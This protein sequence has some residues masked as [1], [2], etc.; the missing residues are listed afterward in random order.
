M[1]CPSCGKT[2]SENALFCTECGSSLERE[3]STGFAARREAPKGSERRGGARLL[4]VGGVVAAV[5]VIAVVII[6]LVCRAAG[7]SGYLVKTEIGYISVTDTLIADSLGNSYDLSEYGIV[8]HRIEA[9]LDGRVAAVLGY[10]SDRGGS[11]MLLL[12]EDK[13]IS[14]LG[15][16]IY[17]C[18]IS[19]NGASVAY[20]QGVDDACILCVYNVKKQTAEEISGGIPAEGDQSI[21]S[22]LGIDSS[23]GLFTLSPDGKSIAYARMV[24]NEIRT[25]AAVGGSEPVAVAA[26]S[27]PIAISNGGKYIYYIRRNISSADYSYKLSVAYGDNV[28]NLCLDAAQLGEYLLFNSDRTEVIYTDKNVSYISRKG[29]ERRQ[30]PG[31]IGSI[32]V[33]ADGAARREEHTCVGRRVDIYAKRT[34]A[35]SAYIFDGGLYYLDSGLQ[36]TCISSLCGGWALS[37]DGGSVYYIDASGTS[38]YSGR[39]YYLKDIEKT[40]DKKLISGDIQAIGITAPDKFDGVYLRDSDNALYFVK[41]GGKQKR[42]ADDIA[43]IT[44]DR[45]S[46][47]VYF[48]SRLDDST[49]VWYSNRGSKKKTVVEGECFDML[50]R[51]IARQAAFFREYV[52]TGS[53]RTVRLCR[54]IS[55]KKYECIAEYNE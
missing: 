31:A 40:A 2:I 42:I 51:N 36:K 45:A 27:Y 18:V 48:T 34:L 11:G 7:G 14:K 37:P 38:G 16:N 10:R 28:R 35:G 17:D 12:I 1:K 52:S 9:S 24:N 33:P 44:V 47:I 13:V 25:Y 15:D 43:D 41:S 39:V 29:G 23:R 26:D 19:D 21:L 49:V 3:R 32:V 20:A 8:S 6:W 53:G 5:A 4:A 54:V 55:G 30:L 50:D 22:L 46:G